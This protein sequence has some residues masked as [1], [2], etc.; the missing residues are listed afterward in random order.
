MNS[1]FPH[2]TRV[3]APV[4]RPAAVA[5]AVTVPVDVFVYQVQ[6]R[7]WC[8]QMTFSFNWKKEQKRQQA[9]QRA[10]LTGVVP[11]TDLVDG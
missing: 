7:K 1:K 2:I 3:A 5:P 6:H 4:T 10:G 11:A 9:N 8:Q